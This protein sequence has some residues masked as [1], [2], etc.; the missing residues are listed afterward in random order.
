[1]DRAYPGAD[2]E[3]HGVVRVAC[4]QGSAQRLDQQPSRLVRPAATKVAQ[5]LPRLAAVELIL[6]SRALGAH[7]MV[8][9]LPR[10]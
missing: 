2:V 4:R 3:E 10:V 5:L 1:M 8:G 7:D 6:D 9:L